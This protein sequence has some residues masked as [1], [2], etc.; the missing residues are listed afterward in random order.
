MLQDGTLRESSS[1]WSSALH[2]V[3][4][5]SGSW[6]FVG[7][8]KRL[9]SVTKKDSY[10]LPYLKD[11]A[12][13]LHNHKVFSTVD[14]RDAYHQ[15][16]IAEE[17][18]EKTALATPFGNFEYT[19][20]SFGLCGA[21]Q[22]FQRF[23]DG[24]M[25]NLKATNAADAS[26]TRKVTSFSYIDDILIASRNEQE[27][28]EDLEALFKRL[29]SYGLKINLNKCTFNVPSLTFLGHHI[30]AKGTSPMHSKVRAIAEYEKPH[31]VQSLRRYIGLINF[32]HSY[33]A[34][35]AHHL[36]PLTSMLGGNSKCNKQQKL[37]WTA[38]ADRAFENS[39]R[40]LSDA[41]LLHYPVRNSETCIVTD[42]SNYAIGG[43]LQQLVDGEWQ[44][45]SFFSY[46]LNK[47]ERNYSAF[48]RELLAIKLSIKHFL[49]YV[50]GTD[51]YILTDHKP[52][53]SA[54]HK[55]TA[56]DFPRE[57]RWLEYISI[58]TTD[59]RHVS[60]TNNVV[61]DALSRHIA[62]RTDDEPP[63][64][65]AH[66]TIAP[67]FANVLQDSLPSAQAN[68]PELKDILLGKYPSLQLSKIN[69][70]YYLPA[71]D[72]LRIYL[73]ATMRRQVFD[74]YHN[75]AHSGIRCSRRYLCQQYI[76][77]FMNKQIG[78]WTKN[79]IECQ[80]AK[81]VKHNTSQVESI[82]PASAK[83]NQIHVDLVGP[84]PVNK[85]C[86]YLL[87]IV[88]RFTRWIEA[89]PIPDA[90]TVTVVDAFMLHWIAR[91]GI[92]S[93]VTTDRGAQF[94]SNLW[95]E[96]MKR[97]GSVKISTTSYHPISSGLIER[98]H[99]RIKDAFRAHIDAHAQIW[100]VHLPLILLN[101]RTA[102]R[103]DA[104]ISPADAVYGCPLTL[105]CDM[106][107][108]I[109]TPPNVSEYTKT[110]IDK[111]HDLQPALSRTP[112]TK[113][114]IDPALKT[115]THVFMRNDAKHGLQQNYSGPYAV[116][117]RH[118]KYFK[119][120]LSRKVDNVSIDRLKAA[121]LSEDFLNNLPRIP[122]N[123]IVVN[124]QPVQQ[125]PEPE[126]PIQP[127]VRR[128]VDRR[129]PRGNYR[130][131]YGRDILPPRYLNDYIW[132]Y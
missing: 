14:L 47:T 90:T 103:D 69:D 70:V 121:H 131:R 60:G 29:D 97:L 116:I 58:Y 83:F 51:F 48:S 85:G 50:E 112:P 3:P 31:T 128:R 114:Y 53:L 18:I 54:M 57:E 106:F 17:D 92:P 52:L 104:P 76:W 36:A 61:A 86:R 67:L 94:E 68:D 100:L 49:P 34:N 98:Q 102:L 2:Y 28:R 88:D 130:N 10:S 32:Y 23:I 30:S 16:P 22:T 59:I 37:I 40:L 1:P 110:L 79:C 9:N 27:H 4:K 33:I 113:S 19:R 87:T 126:R 55:K 74:Q 66:L 107:T 89:I 78:L 123:E 38:E 44:P 20:M 15:I 42:A 43:A 64:S 72:K 71:G 7:D 120:Q 122:N 73:P 80:K 96:L 11:F 39:R 125:Q 12:N 118:P 115:C 25:R 65:N 101:I 62:D 111:M 132:R 41:T 81:V 56:R 99:R 26:E 127:P 84:L 129:N 117:S 46:K 5:R 24:V 109:Y 13:K 105:P 91:F 45:I 95:R 77:P 35:A 124:P 108:K 93:A 6:R 63:T 82:A 8:Y 75:M 21:A 119:L